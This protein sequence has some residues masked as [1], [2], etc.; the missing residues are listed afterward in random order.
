MDTARQAASLDTPPCSVV[1]GEYIAEGYAWQGAV[2]AGE[3]T[4]AAAAAEAGADYDE[5][6]RGH[7]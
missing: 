7:L 6:G 5:H 1:C 4:A 2:N 3:A